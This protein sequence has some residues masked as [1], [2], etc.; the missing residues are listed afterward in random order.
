MKNMQLI[1][2][3]SQIES[4]IQ[5]LCARKDEAW[6]SMEETEAKVEPLMQENPHSMETTEA[7]LHYHCY[8]RDFEAISKIL[9]SYP[10]ELVQ[11]Y[12][13]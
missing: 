2:T 12:M 13:S 11:K 6:R 3:N 8:R 7:V 9:R 4:H 10:T 1:A 5:V